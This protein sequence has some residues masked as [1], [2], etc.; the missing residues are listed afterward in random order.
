MDKKSLSEQ[1]ISSKY[2]LPAIIGAGWDL[3]TQIRGQKTFTAGRIMVHGKTISRGEKK[4][5][6]GRRFVES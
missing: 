2:V 3:E 5:I 1:D 6:C 4:R